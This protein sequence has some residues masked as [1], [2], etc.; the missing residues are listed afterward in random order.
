MPSPLQERD[1][2][3]HWNAPP[4]VDRHELDAVALQHEVEAPLVQAV[5]PSPICGRP[6]EPRRGLDPVVPCG[7][8][9][10]VQGLD[11]RLAREG[12]AHLD[13][14]GGEAHR[15]PVVAVLALGV[16]NIDEGKKER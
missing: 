11:V 8:Q 10:E 6:V 16:P 4:R 5:D 1:R 12:D 3:L 7:G 15:L 14:V 2:G 13:A 9:G